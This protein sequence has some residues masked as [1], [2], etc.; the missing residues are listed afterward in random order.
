MSAVL[1]GSLP[2]AIPVTPAATPEPVAPAPETT[3]V[4]ESEIKEPVAPKTYSEDEV[5]ALRDADAA[6]IRNKLERK[7][8]R[9]RVEAETRSRIEAEH[10]KAPEPQGKPSPDQYTDYAQYLEAL[11]DFKAEQKFNQLKQADVEKDSKARAQSESARTAERQNDMIEAGETKYA[12]FEEVVKS[13]KTQYSQAAFLAMLESDQAH[14]IAYHLAKNQDE[15]KR[16][17]ALPAYAQ[18]KEIGKLEDKLAA[19]KPVKASNAPEPIKPVGGGSSPT[20]DPKTASV[21]DVAAMFKKAG[22]WRFR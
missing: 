16:I 8:E 4:T 13:D 2:S 11:A 22:S 3:A 9:Q 1:D 15:A 7:Y 12:D 14:D 17:A 18:A 20:F 19:K 6:K 10:R 21:D 5:K